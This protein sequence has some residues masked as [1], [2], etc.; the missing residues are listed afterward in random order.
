MAVT[1]MPLLGMLRTKMQWHQA[2]QKLLAENVANADMP[3][4]RPRDLAQ[5][6]FDRSTGLAASTG[7][8]MTLTSVG[9]IAASGDTGVGADPRRVTEFEIRPSGN[10]V[11]LEDEM[12]KVAENQQDYQL[13]TMLYGK[14]LSL[15]KMAVRR[16]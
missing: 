3:G 10:G 11:N 6:S 16:G 12:M 5:P 9:H 2:R 14:G 7:S 4:F 15:L 8:A 1:D 13:A